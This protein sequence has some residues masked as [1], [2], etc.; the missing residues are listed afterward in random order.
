MDKRI[1]KWFLD[2]Y[3]AT[4]SIFKYTD[5]MAYEDFLDDE[6][7]RHAVERN[8]EILGESLVRIRNADEAQLNC[9]RDHHAII[10]MR[11]HIAHGYDDIDYLILWGTIKRSLPLLQEDLQQIGEIKDLL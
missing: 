10:G 7:T 3:Q 6:K 9:V 4:A 1:Q 8:F 11:N 2:A 5:D